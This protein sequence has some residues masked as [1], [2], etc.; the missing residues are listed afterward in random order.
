MPSSWVCVDASLIVR[1]VADPDATGV[2]SL[3]R[4]WDE[5]GRE[6]A[7]PTLVF[8][9]VT[10]ALFRYE[11]HG[12]FGPDDTD[13][14][15]EAALRLPLRLHGDPILHHQALRLARRFALRATYDA[16]YL[17]L[18]ERLGTEFWTCDRRLADAV[19]Q[20]L[21]WVHVAGVEF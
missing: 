6:A 16:H 9:E 13:M 17:A 14:A 2:R 19:G 12:F 1:L 21:P 11:K 18:A 7:A 15:L 8:Y 20:Q 10:N 3:W 5:E 4:S